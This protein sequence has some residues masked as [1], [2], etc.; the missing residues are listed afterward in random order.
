M[1]TAEQ[2]G[3]ALNGTGL[4]PIADAATRLGR[5]PWTLKRWYRDRNLPVVIC[6]DRWSVPESFLVMVE[7]SPK[8]GCA[9]VLEEIAA[10]WF[11]RYAP[12]D[13]AGSAS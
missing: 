12:A 7:R 6:Q 4:V 1:G 5:S 10:E 9:G 8:P 2:T 11:A 3:A 13:V